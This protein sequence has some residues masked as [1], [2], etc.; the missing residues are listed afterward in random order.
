MTAPGESIRGNNNAPIS[1]ER[2]AG[3]LKRLIQ[4]NAGCGGR[5]ESLFVAK[6]T[7]TLGTLFE[8]QQDMVN[9]LRRGPLIPSELH[10]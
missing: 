6:P 8:T 2:E 4:L 1:Q 7:E 9:C 5:P 10:N 3:I